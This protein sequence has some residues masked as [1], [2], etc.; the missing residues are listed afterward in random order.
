MDSLS[1]LFL[2]GYGGWKLFNSVRF[3]FVFGLGI[4]VFGQLQCIGTGQHLK[5]R[6]GNGYQLDLDL[7]IS[8]NMDENQEKR[9]IEKLKKRLIDEFGEIKLIEHNSNRISYELIKNNNIKLGKM[10]NI[11]QDLKDNEFKQIIESY[12]LSQTTLEQVFLRMAKKGEQLKQEQWEKQQKQ[13]GE[14][15]N[16]K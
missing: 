16:E 4:M 14:D 6:F 10:F 8:Q 15:Q 1:L 3:L 5:N 13:N 12:S 9:I 7:N 2:L 11:L